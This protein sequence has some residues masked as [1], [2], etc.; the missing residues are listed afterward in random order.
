MPRLTDHRLKSRS[1]RTGV[2]ST[3]LALLLLAGCSN[4]QIGGA[5]R[6]I[7]AVDSNAVEAM[8]KAE[9]PMKPARTGQVDESDGIWT[10]SHATRRDHGDPLPV[11]W[12]T[13]GVTLSHSSSTMTLRELASKI[14]EGTGI[15]VVF[16]PDINPAILGGGTG[17]AGGASGRNAPAAMN[18]KGA[19]GQALGELGVSGTPVGD[20]SS[21]S[22][23]ETFG[24]SQRVTLSFR[25][26]ALSTL[27]NEGFSFFGLSWRYSDA[28]GGVIHVSRNVMRTF[29][30]NALPLKAVELSGDLSQ[31]LNSAASGSSGQTTSS[32]SGTSSLKTQV[33]LSIRIWDEIVAGV[34]AII[35]ENGENGHVSPEP[36][37]GTLSVMAPD[38]TMDRI[39]SYLERQ[40]A[41]LSKTVVINVD[42]ISLQLQ[43]S[44][45][46]S[47]KLNG[48]LNKANQFALD[49]GTGGA[50][51]LA[52]AA[53]AG[54]AILGNI[55]SAGSS[56][57]TEF[58]LQN[59]SSLGNAEV[60]SHAS[61]TTLNGLPVP[62]SLAQT[63]GYL[64]EV[65]TMVTSTSSASASNSQ[66]T[67]TPGSV[68]VG[69]NIR[70][71]PQVLPDNKRVRLHI[72]AALSDLHGAKNGFDEFS[73]GNQTIQ[74]PNIISRNVQ[75]DATIPSG[76]TIYLSGL[77][78]TST[79]LN[80]S[81]T[82]TPSMLGLGGSQ[83]GQ[84][85]RTMFIIAV[86]P[87]ILTQDVIEYM[88]DS[89]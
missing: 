76:R 15:A 21:A 72:T 64:A 32:S 69:L 34:Q 66:T 55:T 85:A 28:D 73:T 86:T 38:Q 78:Q 77:E 5:D 16:S 88:D 74:L 40:N 12:E 20:E 18:N 60:T 50:T 37:T 35:D 80:K 82:G 3:S 7:N 61:A 68:T 22:L 58:L 52:A 56:N 53:D 8:F 1:R 19:V 6:Q 48:L 45:S 84:R 29:Y 2:I 13:S 57:G 89:H 47:L 79:T 43:A 70:A 31:V 33:D 10:G 54:Q 27:L 17:S 9:L 67:M 4:T 24:D 87:S 62:I 26:G 59:L 75:Q 46:V 14:T 49:Y 71:L 44:D 36:S 23:H 41:I 83:N 63:R 11:R 39:Q 25:S 42:V 81:G 65:Q 51:E 30:I